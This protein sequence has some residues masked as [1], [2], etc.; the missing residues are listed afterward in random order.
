MDVCIKNIKDEDWRLFK[1]E[2]ARHGMKTGDFFSALVE[3]HKELCARPNLKSVLYRK[4][5]LSD[6]DAGNIRKSMKEF[7]EGLKFR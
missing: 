4:K 3:E 7:R 5:T 1:S 6:E 2:S